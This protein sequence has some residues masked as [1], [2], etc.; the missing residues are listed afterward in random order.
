[1]VGRV[2]SD[3]MEKTVVVGVERLYRHRVYKKVIK[4]VKKYKAHDE[5]NACR[6]GDLVQIVE[7][8]PL[9]RH[10]CWV[11]EEILEKAR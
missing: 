11:V 8:R 2:M 10:K 1:L 5:E 3:K 7:S 9:S 4:S 6:I